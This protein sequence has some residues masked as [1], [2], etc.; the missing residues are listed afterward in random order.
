[1]MLRLVRRG[2]RR[3]MSGFRIGLGKRVSRERN[4]ADGL[5]VSDDAQDVLQLLLPATRMIDEIS[6]YQ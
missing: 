1:M 5:L 6:I 4:I 2:L 3:L